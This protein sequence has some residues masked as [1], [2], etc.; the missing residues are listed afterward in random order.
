[1]NKTENL[2]NFQNADNIYVVKY[3]GKSVLNYSIYYTYQNNTY[4]LLC[5]NLPYQKEI[6][7]KYDK[8]PVMQIDTNHGQTIYDII[9]TIKQYNKTAN[10]YKLLGYQPFNYKEV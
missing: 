10:I 6:K 2:Q 8:L 5:H 3:D 9:R 4:L 7:R 1:M